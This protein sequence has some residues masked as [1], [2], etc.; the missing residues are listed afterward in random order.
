MN[1]RAPT[2][3]SRRARPVRLTRARPVHLARACVATRDTVDAPPS[4]G[5]TAR[6]ASLPRIDTSKE[7]R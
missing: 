6:G 7:T 4:A 1:R 3:R 2:V 5:S